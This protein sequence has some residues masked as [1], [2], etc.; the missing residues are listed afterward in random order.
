MGQKLEK[1]S[2]KEQEES[3]DGSDWTEQA[4]NTQRTETNAQNESTHQC[5]D[6]LGGFATIQ[7]TGAISQRSI[8]CLP[9]GHEGKLATDPQTEQPIRNLAQCDPPLY[10]RRKRVGG[11]SQ[12]CGVSRSAEEPKTVQTPK[13]TRQPSEFCL[14][15]HRAS[16]TEATDME[17]R[18][19][20]KY[21]ISVSNL[22]LT[23]SCDP[24][25]EEDFVVL[26]KDDTWLTSNGR[27]KLPFGNMVK[28][29]N[30]QT[31]VAK[32][33]KEN[34][35]VAIDDEKPHH[36]YSNPPEE[37]VNE[38]QICSKTDMTDSVA[39]HTACFGIEMAQR[40]PEVTGSRCH[41]KGVSCVGAA[42]TATTG[43]GKTARQQSLNGCGMGRV[44]PNIPQ[45]HW[46]K[47]NTGSIKR[48][49]CA[50]GLENVFDEEVQL[51]MQEVP[52][53]EEELTR[54]MKA[55]GEFHLE[56]MDPSLSEPGNQD[57]ENQNSQ[58]NEHR[59]QHDNRL[60]G[61]V[62]DRTKGVVSGHEGCDEKIQTASLKKD[63]KLVCFSAVNTKPSLTRAFPKEDTST[64]T[65]LSTVTS[66][67]VTEVNP[68][69]CVPLKDSVPKDKVK[70]KGP[71]PPVPKKPKK[72]FIKLKM[73]K[74]STDAHRRGKDQ[75][76]SEEKVQ[77]SHTF[78]FNKDTPYNTPSNMDMFLLLDNRGAYA[79][80]SNI[81]QMSAD[82]EL[83]QHLPLGQADDQHKD[84]IDFDFCGRLAELSPDDETKN[85][86]MLQKRLFLEKRR[87]YKGSPPPV[88]KKPHKSFASTERILDPE[89]TSEN[90]IQRPKLG[91]SGTSEPEPQQMFDKAEAKVIHSDHNKYGNHKNITGHDSDSDTE[92]SSPLVCYKPVAAII[93]E[94]NQ[95]QRHHGRIKVEGAR[96]QDRVF[97]KNPSISVS[98]MKNAF[99]V[100]KKSTER[101]TEVKA[102]PK[103]GKDFELWK[104]QN[105][106]ACLKCE[107]D[108]T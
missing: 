41:L 62:S 6:N 5:G 37:K 55:N 94:T 93:R 47:H 75:L 89:V 78:H 20:K 25:N 96:A 38:R 50:D 14:G 69:S 74:L 26:E 59:T 42:C 23:A 13:E 104:H 106:H 4:G 108:V 61:S 76:H 65:Q 18:H 63:S 100:P 72:T 46:S 84:M 80:K 95:I 103:K 39:A 56:K 70:V 58:F 87:R 27:G 92:N 51:I 85:L 28:S 90:E 107:D 68:E 31:S 32:G 67:P 22:G 1:T 88:P 17:Q 48:M 34:S 30:L 44:S 21:Q 10:N 12:S 29:E 81:R 36:P 49:R 2:E 86:D 64:E 19:G 7:R 82:P 52:D 66:Q 45:E 83:W 9:A 43:R 98:Q 101:P 33:L 102:P 73:A 16:E 11:G 57:K 54:K 35:S 24:A 71:P 15:V 99:D 97:E 79:K 91:F 3:R 105:I 60:A 40:F 53:D 77:R 8:R